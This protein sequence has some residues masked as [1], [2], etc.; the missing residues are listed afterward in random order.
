MAESKTPTIDWL[1][2][3][4]AEVGMVITGKKDDEAIAAISRRAG[5]TKL[6]ARTALKEYRDWQRAQKADA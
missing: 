2:W 4:P 6:Q 1:R 5:I 3:T